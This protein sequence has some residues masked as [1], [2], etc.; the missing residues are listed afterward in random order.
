MEWVGKNKEN[1]IERV[2]K[3]KLEDLTL[4]GMCKVLSLPVFNERMMKKLSL[5]INA[6]CLRK[7][8][9]EILIN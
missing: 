2:D 4:V 7:E 1:Y 9:L 5:T 8:N 6:F 3:L